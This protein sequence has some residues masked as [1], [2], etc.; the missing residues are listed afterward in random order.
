MCG[1]HIWNKEEN[2]SFRCQAYWTVDISTPLPATG[3]TP[4]HRPPGTTGPREGWAESRGGGPALA[5]CTSSLQTR[6]AGQVSFVLCGTWGPCKTRALTAPSERGQTMTTFHL[7]ELAASHLKTITNP[8][9]HHSFPCQVTQ[10]PGSRGPQVLIGSR[11]L[12]TPA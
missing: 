5:A 4:E 8:V 7:N 9:S 10:D 2:P 1:T 6:S 3:L 12:R 11:I